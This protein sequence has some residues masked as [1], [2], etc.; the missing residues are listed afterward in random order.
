M[1]KLFRETET[2]TRKQYG[3]VCLNYSWISWT[4]QMKQI[5]KKFCI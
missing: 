1:E 2:Y 5:L 3:R 4:H